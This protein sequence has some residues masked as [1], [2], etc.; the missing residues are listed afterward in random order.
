M[1]ILTT[2]QRDQLIAKIQNGE[3]SEADAFEVVLWMRKR[4]CRYK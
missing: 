2:R 3:Y 1:K 4:A